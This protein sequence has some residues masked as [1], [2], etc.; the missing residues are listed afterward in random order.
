MQRAVILRLEHFS[1]QNSIWRIFIFYIW[2]IYKY[3][4]SEYKSVY[5]KTTI[6]SD[7]ITW[8]SLLIFEL[9]IASNNALHYLILL[10]LP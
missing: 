3:I 5:G 9:Y 7:I 1:V 4:L 6:E 2:K 8:L 10:A